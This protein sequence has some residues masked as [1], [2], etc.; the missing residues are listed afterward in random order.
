MGHAVGD[1]TGIFTAF[2]VCGF[3]LDDKSLSDIRKVQI[4]VEFGCGPDFANFDSAVVRRIASDKIR[5]PPV[6]KVQ[7][8]V[9]KK[10]GLV[11]FDGEVVMCVALVD[12]VGGDFALGQSRQRRAAMAK[13]VDSR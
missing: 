6:F 12:Q 13:T 1:F 9:L 4:G 10:S 3:S 5:L 11:V 8:D 2:F 7:R